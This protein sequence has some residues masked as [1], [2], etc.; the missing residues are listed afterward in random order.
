MLVIYDAEIFMFWSNG[1]GWVDKLNLAS[2][3]NPSEAQR[4]TLP[5]GH[6]VQW[7]LKGNFK[8]VN[9]GRCSTEIW[10][11]VDHEEN[12]ICHECGYDSEQCDFPDVA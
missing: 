8:A 4:F 6:N 5:I 1:Y 11:H 12:I 3:F 9:C 10:H 2:K 7:S